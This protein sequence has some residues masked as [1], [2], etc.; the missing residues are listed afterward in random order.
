MLGL[1]FIGAA[2]AVGHHVLQEGETVASVAEE[3]GLTVS[4]LRTLNDLSE[5]EEPPLGTVLMLPISETVQAQKARVLSVTGSGRIT[6]PEQ[7]VVPLACGYWMEPGTTICTS[8]ESYATVRLAADEDEQQIDDIRLSSST[9]LTIIES[10]GGTVGE[11]SSLFNLSE[12]SVQIAQSSEE[13]GRVTVQT[14]QS[15]TTTDGGSFRVTLEENASRVEALSDD[16]VVI[17]AG[18]VV[19]LTE[20][21]G[22][23]I[24]Q[25]EA[26]TTPFV[27]IDSG[28]LVAPDNDSALLRP[29]FAWTPVDAALGYRVQIAT[30]SDFHRILHQEDV[31]FPQW[32]PDFLL[33]PHDVPALWWRVSS[34]DR[35]GF[36]SLPSNPRR[37][38]VP[39]TGQAGE[40]P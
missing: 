5:N 30:S 10:T 9:C 7:E 39:Q 26:P 32:R 16:V 4:A 25:E 36:E 11:R 40:T 13:G 31:P 24:Q 12:G 17:G 15:L 2:F 28:F 37:L 20:G 6:T 29:D 18:E 1:L 34:F 8:V 33:L 38:V 22:S 35:L 21:E 3:E 14:A 23:R 19:Q 27:L